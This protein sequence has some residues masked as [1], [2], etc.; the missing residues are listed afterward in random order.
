[1]KIEND[2]APHFVEFMRASGVRK[3]CGEVPF[4]TVSMEDWQ[5]SLAFGVETLGGNFLQFVGRRL[6]TTFTIDIKE[7]INR[8]LI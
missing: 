5:P 4:A 1:M 6:G 3:Q 7:H 8:R 2:P